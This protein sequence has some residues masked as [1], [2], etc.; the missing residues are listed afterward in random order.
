MGLPAD[1]V[2]AERQAQIVHAVQ[3]PC[4][5]DTQLGAG[6]LVAD[7]EMG[8]GTE[9]CLQGILDVEAN[10]LFAFHAEDVRDGLVL[11]AMGLPL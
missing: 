1:A 10:D 9:Q 6:G 5:G 2:L 3:G 8:A 7:A 4:D 11:Q